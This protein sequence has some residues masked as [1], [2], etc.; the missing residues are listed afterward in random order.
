[1]ALNF[2]FKITPGEPL[3]I[4]GFNR[5]GKDVTLSEMSGS[6]TEDDGLLRYNIMAGYGMSGAP[7]VAQS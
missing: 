5:Q 3:S 1:M 7:I 4:L 6:V 2:H